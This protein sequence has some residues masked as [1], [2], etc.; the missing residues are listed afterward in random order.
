MNPYCS[1][2]PAAFTITRDRT[3]I[4]PISVEG[5]VCP[6]MMYVA[7]PYMLAM[8]DGVRFPWE[9][10]L[11]SVRVTCPAGHV[12]FEVRAIDKNTSR[13]IIFRQDGSCPKHTLNDVITVPIE[14]DKMR[15]FN[16]VFAFLFRVTT[17]DSVVLGRK[18]T[19]QKAATN[20]GHSVHEINPCDVQAEIDKSE[21]PIA[22][23]G[24]KRSC[25]YH[26]KTMIFPKE[27]LAPA[28]LCTMA[29][30]SAYPAFLALLYGK[31]L[32]DTVFLS[33]S[34][35]GSRVDFA[36]ERKA[37]AIKPFLDILEKLL[38]LTPFRL[39]IIKYRVKMRVV[40]VDGVCKKQIKEG[41]CY[42][43]GRKGLFCPSSFYSVFPALISRLGEHEQPSCICTCTSVPCQISYRLGSEKQGISRRSS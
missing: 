22:V 8:K 12:D 13:I 29:Y 9:K 16:E 28:G 26:R 25:A 38:L 43:L 17:S 11:D 30:H 20:E 27:N 41:H 42:T 4:T 21:I 34:G 14:E 7:T 35:T 37:R 10:E 2:D 31:G 18:V 24:M 33:C 15:T 40:A 19:I 32:P 3:A 39:D 6:A 23:A 1:I 5:R 36:L